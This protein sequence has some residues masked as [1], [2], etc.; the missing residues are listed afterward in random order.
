MIRPG[1]IVAAVLL[2]AAPAMAAEEEAVAPEEVTGPPVITAPAAVPPFDP[3]LVARIR[4]IIAERMAEDAQAR[5][6]E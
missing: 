1:R 2:S 4:R 3:E 5:V 6:D